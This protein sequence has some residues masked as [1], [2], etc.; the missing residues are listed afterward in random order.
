M[1]KLMRIVNRPAQIKRATPKA[2]KAYRVEWVEDGRQFVQDFADKASRDAKA[3]HLAKQQT[4]SAEDLIRRKSARIAQRTFVDYQEISFAGQTMRRHLVPFYSWLEQNAKYNVNLGK[5]LIDMVRSGQIDATAA[6]AR[7]VGIATIG[8]SRLAAGMLARFMLPYVLVSLWNST[9]EREEIEKDLSEEDRRRPHIVLG[10]DADG[11]ALVV[12][13]PNA[14][15]DFAEWFY[16]GEL[17]RQVGMVLSGEQSPYHATEEWISGL[18]PNV[19]NKVLQSGAPH[20]KAL[21][22]LGSKKTLF[23]D[24]FDQRT[25]PDS[26]V[27]PYILSQLTDPLVV[28]VFRRVTDKDYYAPKD[29]G[30]W[31]QQLILQVRKRDPESWSYYSIRDKAGAFMEER[32]GRALGFMINNSKDAEVIRNFRKAIRNG[33]A[34]KAMH[35]YQRMLEYGYDSNR[36]KASLRNQHPLGDLMG[37]KYGHLLPEFLDSLQPYEQRQVKLAMKYYSRLQKLE[38]LA[39]TL[40]PKSGTAITPEWLENHQEMI[41]Q[42]KEVIRQIAE[43]N[44]TISAP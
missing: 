29:L 23:P 10:R 24:V 37:N 41:D 26:E 32:T 25:L 31:A 33:N 30:D 19:A 11:K 2:F 14:F 22:T 28:E 7:G 38:P 9:G 44:S 27:A 16:G 34:E 13:T 12:Y 42:R 35:F 17:G 4:K 39:K 20:I 18:A 8:G 15:G 21:Y 36:L 5:N 43:Q 40:F 1:V 6:A 3:E